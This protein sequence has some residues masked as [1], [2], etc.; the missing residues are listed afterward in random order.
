MHLSQ[1]GA[2][3]LALTNLLGSPGRTLIATTT[4][5]LVFSLFAGFL[6]DPRGMP[7]VLRWI[8]YLSPMR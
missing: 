3:V 6:A 8:T 4:L 2:L 7:W 1:I 5:L